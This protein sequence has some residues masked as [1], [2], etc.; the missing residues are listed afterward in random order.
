MVGNTIN[1]FQNKI[2]GQTEEVC[3]QC[4]D[5]RGVVFQKYSMIFSQKAHPCYEKIKKTGKQEIEVEF[6][7]AMKI[8]TNEVI[9]NLD[10]QN[11]P[12]TCN[13][14]NKGCQTVYDGTSLSLADTTK[15]SFARTDVKDGQVSYICV[16]CKNI[17][18]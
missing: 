3:V 17:A 6:G 9:Y 11:C 18:E 12:M 4:T 10:K 14:K 7:G 2:P 8:S 16:F 1:G 13:M 15:I 5:N